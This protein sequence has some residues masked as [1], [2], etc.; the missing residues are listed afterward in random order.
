MLDSLLVN[1]PEGIDTTSWWYLL[2]VILST[3]FVVDLIKKTTWVPKRFTSWIA[4]GLALI[5]SVI[6]GL[7]QGL[8]LPAVILGGLGLGFASSGLRNAVIHP[9]TKKI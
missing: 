9:K 4:P 8:P 6:Y 7:L 2:A 5:V 3:P 1:P